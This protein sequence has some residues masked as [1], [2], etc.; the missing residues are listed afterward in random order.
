MKL[1]ARFLVLGMLLKSPQRKSEFLKNHFTILKSQKKTTTQ[2]GAL[3]GKAQA[4]GCSIGV[5]I[6]YHGHKCI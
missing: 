1:K 4:Q 5:I 6:G 3:P 2:F